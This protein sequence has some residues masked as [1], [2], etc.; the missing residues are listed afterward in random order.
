MASAAKGGAKFEQGPVDASPFSLVREADK[1]QSSPE[2][3]VVTAGAHCVP[4]R[5][6]SV[7]EA[8]VD[9]KNGPSQHRS[10]DRLLRW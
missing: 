5:L 10:R 6:S 8:E 1:R 4:R 2:L 9:C 7:L 3:G